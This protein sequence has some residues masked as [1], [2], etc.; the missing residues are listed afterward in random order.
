MIYKDFS[1][2]GRKVGFASFISAYIK[3][4]DCPSISAE[5][6]KTKKQ[7]NKKKNPQK[8]NEKIQLRREDINLVKTQGNSLFFTFIK[9]TSLPLVHC[10]SSIIVKQNK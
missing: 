7:T 9:M 8:K 6:K 2:S 1:P 4:N 3:N 10:G 5:Q